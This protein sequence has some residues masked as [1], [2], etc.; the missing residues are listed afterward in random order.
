MG[1]GTE[2]RARQSHLT[3]RMSKEER[4]KLNAAAQAVGLTPGS[5]VRSIV[6]SAPIPAQ[7][8]KRPP[9]NKEFARVLGQIGKVGGNLN[10]MAHRLSRGDLVKLKEVETARLELTKI[11]TTLLRVLGR[12]T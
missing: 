5:Y 8:K 11:R 1:S 12:A 4:A 10:Q 7:G 2:K 6:L 9:E 3:F